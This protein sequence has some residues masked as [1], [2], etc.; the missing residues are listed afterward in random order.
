MNPA[1][2]PKIILPGRATHRYSARH[3]L[4]LALMGASLSAC[5]SADNVEVVVTG[6]AVLPQRSVLEEL[7]GSL[8]FTGFDGFD[9]SNSQE[10]RNRGYRKDQIDSVRLLRFSLT[11]TDPANADFDF[12]SAIRFYIEAEGVPRALVAELDPVPSG[13]SQLDLI[14]D[15]ELELRPYLAAPTLNIITEVS[16]LR[17]PQETTVAATAVFDLDVNVSGLL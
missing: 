15:P 16:G 4:W 7:L 13:Q 3:R 6:E 8:T 9:V 1:R 11:I 10:F 12:L 14:V 2:F 17:P 5:S